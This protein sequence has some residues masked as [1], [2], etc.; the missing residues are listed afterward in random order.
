MGLKEL[1]GIATKS[2]AATRNDK[3]RARVLRKLR[4]TEHAAR[5]K[6]KAEGYTRR[7]WIVAVDDDNSGGGSHL[8]TKNLS[9]AEV[10]AIINA[11]ESQWP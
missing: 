7:V 11:L 9:R 8:L 4:D 1:R 10:A 6:P 5:G 3:V 2:A